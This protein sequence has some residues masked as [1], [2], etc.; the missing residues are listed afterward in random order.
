MMAIMFKGILSFFIA[1]CI[2]YQADQYLYE[3]RHA[4]TIFSLAWSAARSVGL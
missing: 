3:G 4:E 1:A 2:L